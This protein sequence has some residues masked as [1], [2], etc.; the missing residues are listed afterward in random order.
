MFLT[1]GTNQQEEKTQCQ[2]DNNEY[3]IHERHGLFSLY[4]CQKDTAKLKDQ[5]VVKM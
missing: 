5:M 3:Y 2:V 4:E 1:I